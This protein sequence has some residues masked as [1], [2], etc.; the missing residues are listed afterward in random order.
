MAD[1]ILIPPFDE[2]DAEARRASTVEVLG[3][4]P[5]PSSLYVDLRYDQDGYYFLIQWIDADDDR[6]TQYKLSYTTDGSTVIDSGFVDSG[7][8]EFV[9]RV[10]QTGPCAIYIASVGENGRRSAHSRSYFYEFQ[11]LLCRLSSP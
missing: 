6:V 5:L 8:Q 10:T 1:I 9:Q 11:N 2:A 3:P 7:V 4:L